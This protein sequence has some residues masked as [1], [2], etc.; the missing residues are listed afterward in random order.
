VRK[1]LLW[2]AVLLFVW[3][4]L[5]YV[6]GGIDWRIGGIWLRSRD[7]F[8]SL[9]IG[10]ALL[11]VQL[12]FYREAF[13]RD[14]DRGIAIGRRLAMPLAF[15]AALV[16]ASIGIR[17]GTFTAGS[18][19][20]YGYVSQ[21]YGWARGELPRPA[22]L[23]LTLDWPSLGDLQ[24]PLGYRP[25]PEPRT[26]VPTYAPGLPLL[27]AA[28]LVLGAC[29]PYLVVPASGAA[30]V[31][32]TFVWGRRAAGPLAGL[33]AAI[34]ILTSPIVVFQVMWP[35]SDVPAAALWTGAM[36]AALHGTRRHAIVAGLLTAAGLLVRPNLPFVALVPIA[37]LAI[38]ARGRERW[39]RL[40]LACLPVA[41]AVI[42]VAALNARWYGGA[43]KTGYGGLEDL[44][45]LSSIGPNLAR[46]PV[47]L[48]QSH[49]GWV[50]AGLAPLFPWFR[51]SPDRRPI[52]AAYALLLV[53][54][55]SYIAYY[56]FEEWWYLRFLLP[57][58]GAIAVLVAGGIVGVARRI[59]KPAGPVVAFIVAVLIVVHATG[60]ST[61]HSMFGGVKE[62]ERRYADVGEYIAR[63]LPENAVVFTMQHSGAVR[64]Y[65]GRMSIRYDFLDKSYTAR[66]VADLERLGYH[67]YLVI[68][69]WETPYV[70]TAFQLPPDTR[71]PWP[72]IASAKALSVVN[73]FD[74]SSRAGH[75]RPVVIASGQAALCQPPRDMMLKAGP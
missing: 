24:S 28:A 32:L 36:V 21:A 53:T 1:L 43:F 54:L 8:R 42:V 6:S 10:S 67:P 25:G 22:A 75:F 5:V 45:S 49:S 30:L 41:A 9:L 63:A 50:L 4:S 20:S 68:D 2:A 23:P 33:V 65:G 62:Q 44:Y 16:L 58:I 35:M 29:G 57:A 40:V 37:Q 26:M 15:A 61:A 19:D 72:L 56:P 73:V 3:G 51:P 38:D 11:L 12:F 7:P 70:R 60:F 14:V 59:P 69:E 64:F 66:A 74:M 34:F 46:Y 18:A 71:L 52:R 39:T 31:W 17:F 48:W 27:M 55:L 13:A 47:W